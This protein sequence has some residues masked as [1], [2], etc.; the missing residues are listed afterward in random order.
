[1]KIQDV[2][3]LQ[4]VLL[5][6]LDISIWSGRKKLKPEDL[7][8]VD[9]PPEQLV[10]LGSKRICDPETTKVFDRLKRRAI[11]ACEEVGVRFLG[12]YAVPVSRSVELADKL[13]A[14]EREFVDARTIFCK[15]YDKNIQE[16]LD[17]DWIVANPNFRAALEVAITPVK[18]VESRLGCHYTACRLAP[19]GDQ[20]VLNRGLEKEVSGLA[21]QLFREIAQAAREALESSFLGKQSIGQRAVNA[22]KKMQSKLA[23]LSFL[24]PQVASVAQTFDDVLMRLPDKG[25]V[26]GQDFQLVLSLMMNLSDESKIIEL[27]RG[28]HAAA[29]G[30]QMAEDEPEIDFETPAQAGVEESATA[31]L[32]QT[33]T[34]ETPVDLGEA[35]PLPDLSPQ[36]ETGIETDSNNEWSHLGQLSTAQALE[37]V[38]EATP[39]AQPTI[40]TTNL[41]VVPPEA[42]PLQSS[43][44]WF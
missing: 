11:R 3:V 2:K 30:V 39:I 19:A 28:F 16:W 34:Q 27:A 17:Q 43:Q 12:G 26:E 1:M 21:G 22:L 36:L 14:I 6:G 29:M 32:P 37:P 9:L 35:D 10:S 7:G 25:D 18:V 23:S 8:V 31:S 40:E 41:K 13:D 4:E 15:D 33:S 20:P 24:N 38:V 5:F 42:P 44:V